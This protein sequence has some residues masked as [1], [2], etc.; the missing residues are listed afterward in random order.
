MCSV[1]AVVL[2]VEDERA[3]EEAADEALV[4]QLVT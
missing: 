4:L 1:Q 2:L 3:A